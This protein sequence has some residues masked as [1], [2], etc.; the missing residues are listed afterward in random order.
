MNIVYKIYINNAYGE[1]NFVESFDEQ[2]KAEQRAVKI[3]SSSKVLETKVTK[4][5]LTFNGK[6]KEIPILSINFDN[7]NN[8]MLIEKHKNRNLVKIKS[9]YVESI[10]I[11]TVILITG[12]ITLTLISIFNIIY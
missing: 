6:L 9:F 4:E 1:Y 8:D 7:N 3:S 12:I 10:K 11:Y 2:Y 5:Y